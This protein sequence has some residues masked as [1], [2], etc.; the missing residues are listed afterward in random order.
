HY[1]WR[2]I[3]E[4]DPFYK[5]EEGRAQRRLFTQAYQRLDVHIGSIVH[6]A[7]DA[8]ILI[9]SD[10]GF[11][12][13]AKYHF[14]LNAWLRQSGCL[15]LD[16]DPEQDWFPAIKSGFF[17]RFLSGSLPQAGGDSGVAWGRTSAWGIPYLS[18]TGGIKIN[19]KSEMEQGF[20]QRGN[21]YN[22]LVR[23]IK[24][25]LQSIKDNKGQPIVEKVY[26]RD[27][28]YRGEFA[29]NAPDILFTLYP[30]YDIPL[31]F[32]ADVSSKEMI[33]PIQNI[34][35]TGNHEREG[36]IVISGGPAVA[37][38]VLPAA[39]IESVA[40]TVLYLLGLPVP[41]DM[42]GVVIRDAIAE[43]YLKTHPVSYGPAQSSR[44]HRKDLED[45]NGWQSNED[46]EGVK[47]RLRD[48][49]YME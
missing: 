42:D 11:I 38:K 9:V 3:N 23:K 2:C 7:G 6:A 18:R 35:L 36:I 39:G 8:V 43:E 13:G 20:I 44:I 33:S 49:G 41:E 31:N 15:F 34:F 5:T 27:E 32:Q 30:Q 4:A 37:G 28:L 47:A 22:K 12:S 14:N 16:G 17:S 45:L 10:H 25:G 40:P 1:F 29:S 46:V 26:S 24:S 21:G 19:V 48:L